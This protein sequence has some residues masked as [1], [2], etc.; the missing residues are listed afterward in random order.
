MPNSRLQYRLCSSVSMNLS[1][2]IFGGTGSNFD[3]CSTFIDHTLSV[4]FLYHKVTVA[5]FA[6]NCTRGKPKDRIRRMLIFFMLF[7]IAVWI[8][9]LPL[10]ACCITPVVVKPVFGSAT[11]FGVPLPLSRKQPACRKVHQKISFRAE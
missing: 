8:Q 11:Y 10:R 6:T 9:I 3:S 4:Y 7:M 1:Q 2:R 5:L